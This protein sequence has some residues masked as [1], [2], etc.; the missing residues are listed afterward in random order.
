MKD[1]FLYFI[2]ALI[3]LSMTAC[4][5][6]RIVDYKTYSNEELGGKEPA[7]LFVSKNYRIK[8]FDGD[9]SSYTPILAGAY[10]ARH[11]YLL[12]GK[13]TIIFGWASEYGAMKGTRTVKFRVENGKY[14]KLTSGF[15]GVFKVVEQ[16][17]PENLPDSTWGLR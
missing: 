4:S 11:I 13:H 6:F 17:R 16:Q 3:L 9:D 12:P 10:G 1:L 8:S 2:S 5:P 14:Y 15:D 7:I